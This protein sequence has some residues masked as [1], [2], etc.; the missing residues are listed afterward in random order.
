[1]QGRQ[2]QIDI[3][4]PGE[5]GCT[6]VLRE[7]ISNESENELSQERNNETL[8]ETSLSRNAVFENPS[9][10]EEDNSNSTLLRS[11]GQMQSRNS[12]DM[13]RNSSFVQRLQ[14]PP[15]ERR[16]S[17]I[18]IWCLLSLVLACILLISGKK[19]L[20]RIGGGLFGVA[21]ILCV[22]MIVESILHSPTRRRPSRD[23]QSRREIVIE[24]P[25]DF[26]ID[27]VRT[28]WCMSSIEV[29]DKDTPPSYRTAVSAPFV[30]SEQK[31]NQGEANNPYF[32]YFP[33]SLFS[34]TDCESCEDVTN[35]PPSYESVVKTFLASYSQRN[36]Q[37]VEPTQARQTESGTDFLSHEQASREHV[38]DMN[39]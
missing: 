18:S 13:P 4:D 12:T 17:C 5:L 34:P 2:Q 22:A 21:I 14:S 3:I 38:V 9:L 31:H 37:E 32:K 35:P 16:L 33:T 10:H 29:C 15:F 26:D 1:M 7:N 39:T 36:S 24:P 27:R 6:T 23:E 25:P 20:Q 19:V 8:S 30:L 28:E 11:G